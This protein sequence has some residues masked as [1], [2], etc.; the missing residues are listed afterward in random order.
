MGD[1][2]HLSLQTG[3]VEKKENVATFFYIFSKRYNQVVKIYFVMLL[4]K[5]NIIF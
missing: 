2:A 4:V 5:E 3:T 1:P